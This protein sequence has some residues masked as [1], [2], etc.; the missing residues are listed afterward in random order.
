[1]A[2]KGVQKIRHIP[3][4]TCI[5]CRQVL[6][7]RALIRLIRT[8]EGIR[9]DTT[10]KLAGRGAYLHN[11]KSCWESGMKNSLAHA[12]RT[13]LTVVDLEYLRAAIAN[14]PEETE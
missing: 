3:Q 8:P 11:N 2:K 7:K 5:G 14:L 10:G 4:R 1:M 13:E 12:L 9:I 6:P